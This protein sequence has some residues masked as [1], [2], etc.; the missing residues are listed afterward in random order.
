MSQ[1]NP[2]ST[3]AVPVSCHDHDQG[4]LDAKVTL[5]E[6]GDYQNPSCRASH[7]LIQ[8]IQAELSN[9]VCYVF[10]HYPQHDQGYKMAEAVEAAYAQSQF[11]QMRQ[12]LLQR[13]TNL[14]DA[15]RCST[16]SSLIWVSCGSCAICPTIAMLTAFTKMCKA[17]E[18]AV[19]SKLQRSF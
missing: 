14:T 3:L 13:S 11:W 16:R 4:L 2:D 8:R 9:C 10:R 6:Y 5:V 12:K 1:A 18:Q 7:R 19:C 17:S 15:I